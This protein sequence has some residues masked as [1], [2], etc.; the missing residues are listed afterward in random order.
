MHDLIR[1]C[2]YE[3]YSSIFRSADA[4]LGRTCS[5]D[6]G[7]ADSICRKIGRMDLDYLRHRSCCPRY[8]L[9]R[10]SFSLNSHE[11]ASQLFFPDYPYSRGF[12]DSYLTPPR[13]A[14]NG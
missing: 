2:K 9:V 5:T 14:R 7:R 4:S 12:T 6:N 8:L 13:Q 3:G 10:R 11:L 1:R